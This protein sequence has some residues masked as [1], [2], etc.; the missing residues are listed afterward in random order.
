MIRTIC[1]LVLAAPLSAWAGP[2]RA[3]VMDLL[4][5]FE[6]PIREADL[7]ALGDGVDAELMEIADDAQVPASR[8]GRAVTGLQ[9]YKTDTV[10]TYLEKQLK[11][12]VS[13]LR[14]K[15]AASLAAWGP[16]AVP[17]LT[18][19]LS[20]SDVQLRIAV[21]QALGRIGDES[22]RKA[23]QERLAS[24]SEPV[25]KEAIDKALGVPR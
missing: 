18:P 17:A 21:A 22:A 12:D 15:A 16:T 24:E 3:A 10:R 25:V 4:N 14:R 7:A 8:R 20:D 2:K 9:Y 19:V 5:A 11:G 6:E 23:L 1:L 13:L